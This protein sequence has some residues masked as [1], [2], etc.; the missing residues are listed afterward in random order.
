MPEAK[1]PDDQYHGVALDC[2]AESS[3]RVVKGNDQMCVEHVTITTSTTA[4][5]L[6]EIEVL[7]AQLAAAQ[8]EL[9]LYRR[10]NTNTD[11]GEVNVNV[12]RDLTKSERLRKLADEITKHT[13]VLQSISDEMTNVTKLPNLREE[14]SM[15]APSSKHAIRLVFII[16]GENVPVVVDARHQLSAARTAALILS[17]VDDGC[18]Y[19]VMDWKITDETGAQLNPNEVIGK[20][21][22]R[23]NV[24]LFIRL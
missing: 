19:T 13:E 24:R 16:N 9:T 21:G 23:N 1:R 3:Y 7:K 6:N 18:H 4:D 5:L 17:H 14:E 12:Q 15:A 22:F 20:F 11:T 2:P 10:H 8:Q